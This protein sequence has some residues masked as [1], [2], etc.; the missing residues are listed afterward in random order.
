MVYKYPVAHPNGGVLE[1]P[2]EGHR[3]RGSC[4]DKIAGIIAMVSYPD[5]RYLYLCSHSNCL[6]RH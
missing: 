1:M 3:K 6:Y 5:T 2:S 4:L